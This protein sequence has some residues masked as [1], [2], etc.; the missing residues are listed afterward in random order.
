MSED[1]FDFEEVDMDIS[2]SRGAAMPPSLDQPRGALFDSSPSLVALEA[3][4]G[5]LAK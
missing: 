2:S 4:H 3:T 5:G 1:V